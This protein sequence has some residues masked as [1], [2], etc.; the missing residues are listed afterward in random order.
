[1]AAVWEDVGYRLNEYSM[2]PGIWGGTSGL[3]DDIVCDNLGRA[4]YGLMH[5]MVL[6][7]IVQ[8]CLLGETGKKCTHGKFSWAYSTLKARVPRA[9]NGTRETHSAI[10]DVFDLSL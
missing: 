1:M 3:E 2:F 6:L 7:S 10:D 5:V 4:L 9:T 8:G